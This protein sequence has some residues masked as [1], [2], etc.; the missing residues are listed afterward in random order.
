MNILNGL[1]SGMVLQRRKR[2]EGGFSFSGESGVRDS[3]DVVVSIEGASKPLRNRKCGKNDKKKFRGVLPNLLPGGPYTVCVSLRKGGEVLESLLVEDV[4]V[5]DVWILAGQS[6]MEGWGLPSPAQLK[7][8]A[9]PLIR[10]FAMNDLWQRARHPLHNIW[11]AVDEVHSLLAGGKP[12]P[13]RNRL[14]GPGLDFAR[15]MLRRTGVPQGLIPCAHGGSSMAQWDPRRKNEGGASLYGAA[16]RRLKKNGGKI[17]GILWSQGSSDAHA[18]AVGSYRKGMLRLI[19]AFRRDSK[20]PLLPFVLVQIPRAVGWN[21][22][23]AKFWNQIQEIQAELPLL[24]PQTGMVPSVDLPYDD[25]FHIS[26]AA[27]VLHGCRLA[28]EMDRL[29]RGT[30]HAPRAL[31]LESLQLGVVEDLGTVK[32][33]LRWDGV[34]G[35]LTA[36]GRPS[37]FVLVDEAGRNKIFAIELHGNEVHLFTCLSNEEL[38]AHKLHYGYLSDP[39]CNITDGALRSLPVFGPVGFEGSPIRSLSIRSHRH[40]ASRASR[41]L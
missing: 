35:V 34:S 4:L 23:L 18:G 32:I 40:A 27:Q 29:I 41:R 15:E 10:C 37:G 19:R 1:S 6:N 8:K 22:G 33:I 20:D 30:K 38:A 11:E 14:V 24:L 7:E 39:F 5:G 26:G 21:S 2:T 36:P 28:M 3:C 13:M 25:N 9:E 12:P 31:R 16:I 17:R